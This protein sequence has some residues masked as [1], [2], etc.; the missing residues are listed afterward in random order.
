MLAARET[1]AYWARKFGLKDRVVSAFVRG[2]RAQRPQL[3]GSGYRT[4][5]GLQCY[6][7]SLRNRKVDMLRFADSALD[8]GAKHD[9]AANVQ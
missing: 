2:F 7:S 8:A 9:D 5:P 6:E 3:V 4:R 1:A